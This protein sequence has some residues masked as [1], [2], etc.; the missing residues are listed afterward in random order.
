M[1]VPS[2]FHRAASPAAAKLA[3]NTTDDKYR[4]VVLVVDDESVIADSLTTILVRSGYL[5][6][7]AYD[8]ESALESALHMPPEMLITDV[9]LPGMSGIELSIIIKRVFPDCKIILFSGQSATADMLASAGREGHRFEFLAKP[10][11]PRD[12]L[13]RVSATL[14]EK[15]ISAAVIGS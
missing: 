3:P 11:H 7:T 5:A 6:I 10:V 15:G 12:L 8:G 2:D 4:P 14:K 1:G 13:A 9:A